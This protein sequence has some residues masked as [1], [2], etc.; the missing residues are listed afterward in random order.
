MEEHL[1]VYDAKTAQYLPQDGSRNIPSRKV[2]E[3]V[4]ALGQPKATST[5]TAAKTKSTPV[6]TIEVE[7]EQHPAEE[8]NRVDMEAVR[9]KLVLS[10]SK[11]LKIKDELKALERK[12]KLV[13]MNDP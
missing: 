8:D 4:Q 6:L 13:I 2:S 9:Q 10:A 12:L 7:T 1:S 5:P 3:P 11:V